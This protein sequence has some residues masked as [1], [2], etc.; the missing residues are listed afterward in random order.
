MR[1]ILFLYW[2]NLSTIEPMIPILSY[3]K[4]LGLI[5]SRTLLIQN[6]QTVFLRLFMS[7]L[8]SIGILDRMLLILLANE[9][10]THANFCHAKKQG[11]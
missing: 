5:L 11:N 1:Q 2:R 6:N 7:C 4:S 3:V 10:V 9:K 8:F